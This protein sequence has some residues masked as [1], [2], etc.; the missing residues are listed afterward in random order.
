[1]NLK[2]DLWPHAVHSEWLLHAQ[3]DVCSKSW[4]G[5]LTHSLFKDI[6]SS[7]SVTMYKHSQAVFSTVKLGTRHFDVFFKSAS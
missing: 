4:P 5:L 6:R 7:S 1:M 2:P 3:I